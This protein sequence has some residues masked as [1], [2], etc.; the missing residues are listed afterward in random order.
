MKSPKKITAPIAL[1]DGMAVSIG[2]VIIGLWLTFQSDRDIETRK[3]IATA[4][5]TIAGG[6][7]AMI[8]VHASIKRS[9]AMQSQ[10]QSA[11]K[12]AQA[13]LADQQAKRFYEASAALNTKPG[14]LQASEYTLLAAIYSLGQIAKTAEDFYWPALHVLCSFVRLNCQEEPGGGEDDD[15]NV[16]EILV[17]RTLAQT[18]LT[19]IGARADPPPGPSQTLDLHGIHF[20]MCNLRDANLAGAD[21]TDAKLKGA[22]LHGACLK[23]A[24]LCGTN[25]SEAHAVGADLRNANLLEAN[26]EQALLL[27][28]KFGGAV[29]EPWPPSIGRAL[30]HSTSGVDNS[31]ITAAQ[32]SMCTWSEGRSPIVSQTMM[33][34]VTALRGDL[35]SSP[36]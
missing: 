13:T 33:A 10:A 8:G 11:N 12:T 20:D 31:D 15:I 5:F 21:L 18:A 27:D 17:A 2:V 4:T 9:D 34:E 35:H 3:L 23:G 1:P 24:F 19:E 25:L 16:T 29:L 36:D 30:L 32:L 6:I 22:R 14:E 28:T 7:L 26:L